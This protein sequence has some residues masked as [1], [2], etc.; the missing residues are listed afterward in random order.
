MRKPSMS[1]LLLASVRESSPANNMRRLNKNTFVT[2]WTK[3]KKKTLLLGFSENENASS[4]DF[5]VELDQK[6]VENTI[7]AFAAHLMQVD[8]EEIRL[9]AKQLNVLIDDES[10]NKTDLQ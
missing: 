6:N 8:V 2:V 1:G 5:Y 7:V 4:P 3:S 9:I 10:P